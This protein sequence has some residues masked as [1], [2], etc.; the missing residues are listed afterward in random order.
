MSQGTSAPLTSTR[1]SAG[2]T[3]NFAGAVASADAE[4]ARRAL[5]GIQFMPELV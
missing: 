3:G 5:T 4:V 2:S 1:L